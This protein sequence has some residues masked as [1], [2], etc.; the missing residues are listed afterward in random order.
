MLGQALRAFARLIGVDDDRAEDALHSERVA[1]HVTRRGF[2]GAAAALATGSVFSFA[3]LPLQILEG[4]RILP[5]SGVG[6]FDAMVK[7]IYSE[8]SILSY[9]LG[10]QPL[11]SVLPQ[12]DFLVVPR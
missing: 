4:R 11:F 5:G 10:A 12:R 3:E 1:H 2:L 9:T 7:R 8:K 6:N